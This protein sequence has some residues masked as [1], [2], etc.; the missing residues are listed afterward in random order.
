[1]NS[2]TY[3][4]IYLHIYIYIHMHTHIHMY[5]Y[6]HA[7]MHACIHACVYVHTGTH[8][9][10]ASS[11]SH[12]EAGIDFHLLWLLRLLLFLGS[13]KDGGP[14]NRIGFGGVLI[15]FIRSKSK[16]SHQKSFPTPLLWLWGVRFGSLSFWVLGC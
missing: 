4:H 1:M 16:H 8:G 15:L 11:C 10:Q 13:S 12:W 7:C 6:M 5:V 3:R 9:Q 14:G 2:S